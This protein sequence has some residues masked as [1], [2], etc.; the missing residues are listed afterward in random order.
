MAPLNGS[1]YNGTTNYVLNNTISLTTNKKAVKDQFTLI[2][3]DALES[4]TNYL[5][6]DG[7][8]GLV[9]ANSKGEQASVDW[10]K[11]TDTSVV[12]TRNANG[13][14]N[15]H[16]LLVLTDKAPKGVGA[17]IVTD[18]EAASVQPGVT[19]IVAAPKTGDST[20][21]VLY[22]IIALLSVAAVTGVVIYERRKR[23]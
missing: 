16:D 5:L 22:V 2:G 11:S 21:M 15:M 8:S 20:N 6:V 18:G 9:S 14:I 4:E 3:Q 7:A 17:V 23:A 10:F 13:S 19:N 12:P 1:K